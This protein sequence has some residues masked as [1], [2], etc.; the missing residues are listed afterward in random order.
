MAFNLNNITDSIIRGQS[1]SGGFLGGLGGTGLTN[2]WGVP[3]PTKNAFKIAEVTITDSA[4]G[5]RLTLAW[6]PEKISVKKN[7]RFQSYNI[8]EKGEVKIPRGDNLAEVSWSSIFPGEKRKGYSFLKTANWKAPAEVI[9][10]IDTWRKSGAKLKLMITQ[11]SV[12][13]DVYIKDFSFE[14]SGGMGDTEYNISFIKAEDMIIKTVEEEDG[15]SPLNSRPE[16]PKP[17]TTTTVKP[18]DSLWGIAEEKLGDGS[19]WPE[20][21]DLNRDKI[22]DPD[23]IYPGQEL[24]M[25]N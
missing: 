9:E 19:R 20:I 1:V 6:T 18:G 25:P 22:S 8:I 4:G 17:K 23:L 13:M 21:Y 7:G 2:K 14:F 11:T 12:N 10:I 24:N 5:Q 3:I 15:K 16:P